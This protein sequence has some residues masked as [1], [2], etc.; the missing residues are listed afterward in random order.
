LVV[1]YE[2]QGKTVSFIN[3]ILEKEVEEAN[4]AGSL[5]RANSMASKLMKSYSTMIGKPF[6]RQVLS[7]SV[8]SI[9]EMKESF[10][11]D[12]EKLQPDEKLMDNRARLEDACSKF[13]RN[14]FDSV[15]DT[16]IEFR[17]ICQFMQQKV[18]AKFPGNAQLCI[19][20]WIFLRYFCPA[21]FTP[22]ISGI[23]T[24]MPN[25]KSQRGLTLIAKTLQNIAN[26]VT[27]GKKEDSLEWLN[28]FITNNL[29]ACQD[30][31]DELAR[32]PKKAKGTLTK[33]ISDEQRMAA[34]ES[35]A[36]NLEPIASKL[37]ELPDS[38]AYFSKV[39]SIISDLA[40]YRA[41]SGEV[42]LER[43]SS[44]R[45]RKSS[46]RDRKS[47]DRERKSIEKQKR[48]LDKERKSSEK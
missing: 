1:F 37:Q 18:A 48:S 46:D 10:E 44:D 4:Y 35:L 45:D 31:F 23:V 19:G 3:V 13:L 7:E 6:L 16:P 25:E 30:Y 11:V 2:S 8:K 40:K 5:M 41:A 43:K 20:G 33:G 24:T 32:I 34:L 15:D 22:M 39:E 17:Q 12:P 29:L 27:F 38:K 26:N 28:K 9:C 14:I 21:I 36:K 47:S 42:P